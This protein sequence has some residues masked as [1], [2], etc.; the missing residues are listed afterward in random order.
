M[1]I[2]SLL[3]LLFIS[4]E[5]F[6]QCPPDL[7]INLEKD[8][9]TCNTPTIN[10]YALSSSSNVTFLWAG[11]CLMNPV[12][13]SSLVLPANCGTQGFP[14]PYYLY[15]VTATNTLLGC[16]TSTVV[17]VY[18]NFKPPISSPKIIGNNSVICQNNTV[19][20]GL[21]NSTTTSGISGAT[22]IN[23]FWESPSGTFTNAVNFNAAT[24]GTH[25]LTVTDSYNGCKSTGTVLVTDSRPQFNLQGMAPTTSVSCNGSVTINTQI[26]N[27][28]SLS[29]TSGSLNGTTISN[30]CYGWVKVCM[31]LTNS[32]CFKCDSLLINAAT[33][34]DEN[35]W[36]KEVLIF[37]N[38]SNGNLNITYPLREKTKIKIFDLEG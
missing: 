1:K 28:Y 37:P 24:A 35:D 3:I 19:L 22:V 20:L 18:F 32:Q 13:Q 10:A 8:T 6:G 16:S 34:I 5:V 31:T 7:Q 30:L 25:S 38:P 33:S 12:T 21:G 23:P 14:P 9:V 2:F 15:S 27:G 17:K 26:P 36:E 29:T 11:Y 4:S